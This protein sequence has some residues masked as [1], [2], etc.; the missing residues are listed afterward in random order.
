[1]PI[2]P[3]DIVTGTFVATTRAVQ[4][5]APGTPLYI[6]SISLPFIAVRAISN[7]TSNPF[8]LTVDTCLYKIS[9]EYVRTF[10][11]PV[12]VS[13]TTSLR[14]YSVEDHDEHSTSPNE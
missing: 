14:G 12:T 13:D 2:Q 4:G 6:I 9:D 7:S 11:P 3:D 1:M 10:F 5:Y 8:P